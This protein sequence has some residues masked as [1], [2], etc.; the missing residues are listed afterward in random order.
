MFWT[1]P[2]VP[3]DLPSE[4]ARAYDLLADLRPTDNYVEKQGR[5]TG[6]YHL[7]SPSGQVAVYVKKYLR[8]PWW[9]RRFVPLR[10]FP[11]PAEWLRLQ[12]AE[13]LGILVPTAVATGADRHHRCGSFLAIR[14]LTGF[15]PLHQVLARPLDSATL[16]PSQKRALLRRVAE[17]ARRLHTAHLYHRDLYLCHFFLRPDPQVPDGFELA[18][19][20]FT[21]L[22]HSGRERWRIKDLAQLS[23]SADQPD[24]S[25]TD[26]L[27]FL[28]HYLGL[29]HLDRSARRLLTRIEAQGRPVSTT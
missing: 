5:S 23:F 25:R 20:D 12:Q 9:L 27:R 16:S 13:Q 17:I 11:G 1:N 29:R 21:R 24:V 3:L 26:R 19:I 8:L 28:K 22:K 7:A 6:R 18:L 4:P 2:R 15:L 14:E 10:L